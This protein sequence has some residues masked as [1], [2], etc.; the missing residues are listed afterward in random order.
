MNISIFK[1]PGNPASEEIL[2]YPSISQSN[3]APDTFSTKYLTSGRTCPQN[4]VQ[5]TL[6]QNI[7][8]LTLSGS[9]EQTGI[10]TAAGIFI[11]RLLCVEHMGIIQNCQIKYLAAKISKSKAA[12]RQV[13]MNEHASQQTRQMKCPVQFGSAQ[14]T[15]QLLDFRNWISMLSTVSL[16]FFALLHQSSYHSVSLMISSQDTQ[17]LF[18]QIWQMMRHTE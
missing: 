18:L 14:A 4:T 13:H 3:M 15:R 6:P 1:A 10:T 9:S 5:E 8:D 2:I 11:E 7:A 12:E 16:K 17:C